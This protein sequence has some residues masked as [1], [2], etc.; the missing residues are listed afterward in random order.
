MAPKSFDENDLEGIRD[1]FESHTFKTAGCW[2]WQGRIKD[3]EGCM[4]I[5]GKRTSIRRISWRLHTGE[6]L[7]PTERLR[8]SCLEQTCVNPDHMY[9]DI[10]R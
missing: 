1:F 2:Y 9:I 6:I 4:F 3:R 8:V 5:S 10:R 7:D